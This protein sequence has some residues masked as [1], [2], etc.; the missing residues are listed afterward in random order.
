LVRE[1]VAVG[2][3]SARHSQLRNPASP[4]LSPSHQPPTAA[5][6]LHAVHD[7]VCAVVKVEH[8]DRRAGLQHPRQL[9]ERA[10]DVCHIAQPVPDRRGVKAAVLKRQRERVAL[11]PPHARERARRGAGGFLTGPAGLG[12][13]QH[14]LSEVE[15]DDR[16]RRPDGAGQ[17][18]REV[19]RAAA[20]V[21]RGVA[22]RG[23]GPADGHALPD[24]VL[25][26]AEALVELVGSGWVRGWGGGGEVGGGV[27]SAD[28]RGHASAGCCGASNMSQACRRPQRLFLPPPKSKTGG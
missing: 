18:E 23:A 7:G 6:H 12:V 2:G 14:L 1:S 26:E 17:L 3:R 11:D 16:S 9:S 25:A 10:R 8:R 22:G 28:M 20:D 27:G 19:P 21:E 15:A 5:P 24:A 13:F 4:F